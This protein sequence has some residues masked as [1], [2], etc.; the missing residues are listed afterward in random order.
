MNKPP[1]HTPKP[2]KNAKNQPFPPTKFVKSGAYPL[3]I[4]GA[5]KFV[6]FG[7]WVL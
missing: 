3:V 5:W 4:F 2:Q 6:I 7:T 1:T